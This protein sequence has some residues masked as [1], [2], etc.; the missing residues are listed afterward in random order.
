M[1]AA[2]SQALLSSTG[3]SGETGENTADSIS[4]VQTFLQRE[5]STR[6]SQITFCYKSSQGSS[7]AFMKA[8]LTNSIILN[9]NVGKVTYEFG[10]DTRLTGYTSMTVKV[11]YGS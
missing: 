8:T 3:L 7:Q 10:A 9:N 5:L 1:D 11:T 2:S 4:A 6:Q